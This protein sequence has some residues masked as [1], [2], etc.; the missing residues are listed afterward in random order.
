MYCPQQLP[1]F[2][3]VEETVS[4]SQSPVIKRRQRKR[5]SKLK[6]SRVRT[7]VQCNWCG[8]TETTEWR[9]GPDHE[10]LCNPCGLQWGK[11]KKKKVLEEQHEGDI[12]ETEVIESHS[13]HSV[14]GKFPISILLN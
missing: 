12:E 11:L 5:P 9:R 4:P 10:L 8:V 3:T 14:E 6:R 2:C 7:G 1:T 13:H